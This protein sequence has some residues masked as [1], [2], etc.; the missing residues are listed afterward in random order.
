MESA[1]TA[2]PGPAE[3]ET[4]IFRGGWGE[5]VRTPPPVSM[6]SKLRK[7]KLKVNK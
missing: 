1:E 6:I 3:L 7:K 4:K 5:K 2:E